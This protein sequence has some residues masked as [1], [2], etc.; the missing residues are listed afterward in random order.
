M[1]QLAEALD[2]QMLRDG[3]ISDTDLIDSI[4]SDM[5]RVSMLEIAV[6]G[7]KL[8]VNMRFIDG[9]RKG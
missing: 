8:A 5:E 9:P 2:R 7:P 4:I 3:G 6:T 1:R